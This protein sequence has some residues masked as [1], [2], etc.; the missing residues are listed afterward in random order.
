MPPVISRVAN[1]I[2]AVR[3][4]LGPASRSAT[5]QR[6]RAGRKP[7]SRDRLPSCVMGPRASAGAGAVATEL[8][9]Q[10]EPRNRRR[11]GRKL[12]GPRAAITRVV[13]QL[14]PLA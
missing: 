5:N 3:P 14:D 4:S 10:S 8:A 6:R 11:H 7:L 13:E 1:A 9:P 12:A 2:E